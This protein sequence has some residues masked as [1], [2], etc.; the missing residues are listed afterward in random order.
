MKVVVLNGSPRQGNTKDV[1]DAFI[2]GSK[3]LEITK[4][5]LRTSKVAPCVACEA[6]TKLKGSCKDKDSTNEILGSI[7]EADAIVF[8][9]PIYWWGMTAQL[10]AVVDKMYA[11]KGLDWDIPKKKIGLL[12]VGGAPTGTSGYEIISSQVKEIGKYLEWDVRFIEEVQAYQI[13]EAKQNT[14]KIESIKE[15]YQKLL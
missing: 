8:A 14:S 11:F 1:V 12:I 10:K 7:K 5:D 2:E 6:C 4:Y 15:L 3:G 13:G 9:T